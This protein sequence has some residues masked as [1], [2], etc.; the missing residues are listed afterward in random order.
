[1]LSPPLTGADSLAA[2]TAEAERRGECEAPCEE[3]AAPTSPL[4][5][6]RS[7][8]GAA[9][10]AAAALAGLPAVAAPGVGSLLGGQKKARK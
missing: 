4:V 10:A 2:P 3:A 1:M 8:A 6:R 9:A 7:I 5:G